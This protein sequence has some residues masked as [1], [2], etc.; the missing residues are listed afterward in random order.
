MAR[1]SLA[2]KSTGTSKSAK[3][4]AS[5]PEARKKKNAYNTEYHA[6]PSRVKYREELNAAN[7]KSGTYGN[8][9]GKDKSHTK[10]GA[11]VNEKA[12]TNRARNGKGNNPRR[13]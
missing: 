11:L 3:Y 4:F 13:R 2:G 1:N 12:S 6:A 8:G 5:H 10:K 7:R 9:D